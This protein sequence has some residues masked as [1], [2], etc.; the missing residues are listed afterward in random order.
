MNPNPF[1]GLPFSISM[2]SEETKSS[3]LFRNLSKGLAWF[4]VILVAFVLLETYVKE[5]FKAH[6]GSIGENPVLMYSIFT[7]SEIVFGLIPPEFFMMIWI[8]QNVTVAEYVLNLTALTIISYGAGVLGY[9]IG[10]FFTKTPWYQRVNQ[11]YLSQYDRQLKKFG[12]Y[13]VFVG[14]VTPV[15]FSATCMLA[16]SVS[17]K[18]R[19]FLLICITR[20]LRFAVYGYLVWAFP[21]WFN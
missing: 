9:F 14:A 19:D 13:L 2:Q 17:L 8:L 20:V 3:F 5:D 21:N 4:A 15:P 6:V 11:K 16:G 1:K 12:G 7:A 10:R 18:F